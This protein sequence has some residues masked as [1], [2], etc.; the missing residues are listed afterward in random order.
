MKLIREFG[1]GGKW[2]KPCFTEMGGK[3]PGIV[4][5]NTDIDKAVVAVYKSAFGLS[6][7]KCSELSRIYVQQDIKKEFTEKLI[8]TVKKLVIG[9]PTK[10]EVFV[11]PVVD[12][13]ALKK[14]QWAVGEA[15]KNGG[16]ILC[17]GEDLQARS[18]FKHGYF[19]SPTIVE[20]PQ[21]HTLTKE[22][23]FLPFLNLY[24]F[25]TLEE[26]V[27]LANDCDYGLTAGIFSNDE[28][29]LDYFFDNIESGVTYA[30]RPTGITTGAWPG[31]NSFCGWKGSGG[32][33]KGFCGPYYVSQ[34]GREQSQTRHPHG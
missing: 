19:V 25:N 12:G 30:N 27:K 11:G 28:K 21:T 9:D 14:Y 26:A 24:S 20:V 15:P 17:G 4:C 32:S 10:K 22:E 1:T 34:F 31:V 7:Q 3:N 2:V 5:K 6:G 13:R 8:D 18:E 29:E 23:L 16:K 33:G